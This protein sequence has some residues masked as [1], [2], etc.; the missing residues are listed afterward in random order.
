MDKST[1][2]R[3]TAV[4]AA[5]AHRPNL[6]GAVHKGLRACMADTLVAVGGADVADP[7][8][9]TLALECTRA[10]LELCLAHLEHENNFIHRAMERVQ[11]GSSQR[12]SDDHEEHLQAISA[13]RRARP[14][15]SAPTQ[16]T[17]AHAMQALYEQLSLFIAH[18]FEHMR[19][20]ETENMTVL[21]THL[22]DAG[23]G[24]IHHQIVAAIPPEQMNHFMRWMI[25]AVSHA[26][27][28]A[29]IEGMRATAPAQAFEAAF[30]IARER[31]A[32]PALSRLARALGV[33]VTPVLVE[34][35]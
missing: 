18:N 8:E 7:R 34:Q 19:V 30:A 2:S 31:L 27:R 35:W 3:T 6:Y 11:P 15:S 9:F 22:D 14:T 33:P 25:P 17:R 4:A 23:L 1:L 13:L 26:E 5:A 24:A 10:L 28:L 12:T 20:E 16:R 29:M 32:P 21:W